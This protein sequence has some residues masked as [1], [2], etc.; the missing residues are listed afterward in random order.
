MDVSVSLEQLAANVEAIKVWE[1]S[2]MPCSSHKDFDA[3]SKENVR[4]C[5]HFVKGGRLFAKI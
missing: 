5:Q 4:Y 2:A 3:F 1:Y